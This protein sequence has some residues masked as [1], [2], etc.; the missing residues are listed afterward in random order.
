MFLAIV[1]KRMPV[2]VFDEKPK[3]FAAFKELLKK[4]GEGETGQEGKKIL[5]DDLFA[6]LPRFFP[7]KTDARL[8]KLKAVIDEMQP[9]SVVDTTKLFKKEEGEC[10]NKLRK[11]ITQQYFEEYEEVMSSLEAEIRQSSGGKVTK[12]Y[13]I[14]K[15]KCLW[16]SPIKLHS[17]LATG[18][19][20]SLQ[21]VVQ[22]LE[23]TS[24]FLASWVVDVSQFMR[25]LRQ[26]IFV[27]LMSYY[28][29]NAVP[30][31]VHGNSQKIFEQKS[32]AIMRWNVL[33]ILRNIK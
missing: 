10:L 29:P 17:Y 4:I 19:G 12:I 24:E 1:H 3:L 5:K 18:I 11:E 2:Q 20:V 21:E 25:N 6:T 33:R 16:L 7:D 30:L 23:G 26:G 9:H 14:T 32:Q 27:E 13:Q 28:E 8:S 22:R 31:I 15:K